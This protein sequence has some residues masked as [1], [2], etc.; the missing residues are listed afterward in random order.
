MKKKE[1]QIITLRI[2]DHWLEDPGI[3]QEVDF[4]PWTSI[5]KVYHRDSNVGPQDKE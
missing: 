5:P 3:G 4:I 1:S 2:W